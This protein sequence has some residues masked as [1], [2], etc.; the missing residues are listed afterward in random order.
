MKETGLIMTEHKE[1]NGLSSYDRIT[2]FD[3]LET[4][5][6]FGCYIASSFARY[7]YGITMASIATTFFDAHV[8]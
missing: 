5:A 4:L 8:W 6:A 3:S 7:N 2:S 1:N